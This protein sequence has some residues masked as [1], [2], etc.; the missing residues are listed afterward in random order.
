MTLFARRLPVQSQDT[1]DK[2]SH[3]IPLGTPT[4][5]WFTRRRRRTRQ[6]RPN[7]PT[8]NTIRLRKMA[9][10]GLHSCQK[11]TAHYPDDGQRLLSEW[12]GKLCGCEVAELFI[13]VRRPARYS[14]KISGVASA[15]MGEFTAEL[16]QNSR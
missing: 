12:R 1:V 2:N 16:I 9:L 15:I 6:C 7:R 3:L 5:C 4:Q 8:V 14:S 11:P 10:L 13:W